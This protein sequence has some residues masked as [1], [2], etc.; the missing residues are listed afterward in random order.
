MNITVYCGANPGRDPEFIKR[1][2]ELGTWMGQNGHRLV[3]GAGKDGMMGAV[4]N[5]VLEAG[6]EVIGV[7]PD[8]FIIAEETHCELTELRITADLPE[9]RQMMIAEGDAFIALPGGTGTLDEITEVM[10]LRRLGKLGDKRRPVMLYNIN[11]YYDRLFE[12]LDRMTDEE[13]HRPS[14]RE[15]ILEVCSIEDIEKVL[16]TAGE[17]VPER[18]TLYDK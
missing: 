8:F 1:A 12:F 6:G 5:A 3:Y 18:N 13:F 7:T 15:N 17:P 2:A 4:S 16:S 9:R 14:D 10:S 11:G